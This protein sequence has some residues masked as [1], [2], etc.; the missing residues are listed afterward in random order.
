MTRW[1]TADEQVAWRH[2][3]R[4]TVL[5]TQRLDEGLERRNDLTGTDYEI[6]VILSETPDHRL[7]MSDLADQVLVSRSRLT[8][9]IDQLVRRGFVERQT[10]ESDGRGLHASLTDAGLA[11]I[12]AAAPGHVDDVR[13]H[14]IDH[15]DPSL[16]PAFTELFRRVEQ[17]IGDSQQVG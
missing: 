12:R 16:L 17:S 7:R 4:S 11:A 8:Y 10:C 13:R 2:F 3:L 9:R 6:L 14:L 1:L 5:L 15:I